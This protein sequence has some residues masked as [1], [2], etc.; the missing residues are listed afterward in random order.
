MEVDFDVVADRQEMK[1]ETK[2]KQ[3]DKEVETLKLSIW[4]TSKSH[5]YNGFSLM[6]CSYLF[7]HLN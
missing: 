2:E 3:E 7:S 4:S 5:E 6:C 1:S